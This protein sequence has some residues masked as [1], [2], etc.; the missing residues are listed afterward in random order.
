MLVFAFIYNT[1]VT[2]FGKTLPEKKIGKKT[3]ISFSFQLI[4]NKNQNNSLILLFIAD[5]IIKTLK[6]YK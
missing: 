5:D 1:N 2:K 4:S 3:Y 6:N